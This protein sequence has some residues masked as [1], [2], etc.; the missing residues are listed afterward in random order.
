MGRARRGLTIVEVLIVGA[1][2]VTVVGLLI[3]AVLRIR[4]TAERN[5]CSDNL[6]RLGMALHAYHDGYNSFPI[7]CDMNPSVYGYSPKGN[8]GRQKYWMLSWSTRILPY[9][10]QDNLYRQMDIAQDDMQ[11]AIPDRYFPFDNSRFVA[12]GVSLPVFHCPSDS[13]SFQ[14]ETL[15]GLRVGCTSYLGVSGV[16]TMG[17][18]LGLAP[19]EN[20][21]DIRPLETDPATGRQTGC[22]G[23]LIPRANTHSSGPPGIRIADIK[24]GLGNTLMV[25][26]RPPSMDLAFG[27]MFA[28]YG[29]TGVGDVSVVMG[30]SERAASFGSPTKELSCAKLGNADGSSLNS[31]RF[32]PGSLTNYCDALHFW[33]LHAGGGHFAMADG[34]VRFFSYDM[35]SP[36]Q[37]AMATRTPPETGREELTPDGQ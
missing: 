10:E 32:E 7:A 17:S 37:R 27:W 33:S 18:Q 2:V 34:S 26:E 8:F 30:I 23:V 22:N 35:S 31:W 4:A 19:E 21:T 15:Q 24:R 3:P 36:L 16:T 6:R 9:L 20:P 5:H 1:L 12:L 13:R 14:A 25:G 29:N 28:G 11:V